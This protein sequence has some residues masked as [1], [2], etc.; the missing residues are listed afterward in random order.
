[1]SNGELRA[2]LDR[3]R[4]VISRPGVTG[5]LLHTEGSHFQALEGDAETIDSLYAKI[6]HDRRHT[7]G[8]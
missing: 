4:I 8:V 5:I 1:M 2:I 3:A 6:G 7:N